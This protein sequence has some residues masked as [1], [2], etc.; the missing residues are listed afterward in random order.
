MIRNNKDIKIITISQLAVWYL[1]ENNMLSRYNSSSCCNSGILCSLLL[2][3]ELQLFQQHKRLHQQQQQQLSFSSG[4]KNKKNVVAAGSDE[5]ELNQA[6]KEHHDYKEFRYTLKKSKQFNINRS[7]KEQMGL[8]DNQTLSKDELHEKFLQR[9]NKK[10]PKESSHQHQQQQQQQQ[11]QQKQELQLQPNQQQKQEQQQM[12]LQQQISQQPELV[13]SRSTDVIDRRLP[14]VWPTHSQLDHQYDDTAGALRTPDNS[15]LDSILSLIQNSLRQLHKR[16]LNVLA[17]SSE[18]TGVSINRLSQNQSLFFKA[19]THPNSVESI[20]MNIFI[21]KNLE[22]EIFKVLEEAM[23]EQFKVKTTATTTTEQQHSKDKERDKDSNSSTAMKD[24]ETSHIKRYNETDYLKRFEDLTGFLSHPVPI[25][26]ASA[27]HPIDYSH[28]GQ[29][30]LQLI[31]SPGITNE[32]HLFD[33]L[34]HQT[35]GLKSS[36]QL[37]PESTTEILSSSTI[38]KGSGT[39]NSSNSSSSSNSNNSTSSNSNNNIRQTEFE[40]WNAN[41]RK[42][43][44]RLIKS[45]WYKQVPRIVSQGVN[46][47][48]SMGVAPNCANYIERYFIN[49]HSQQISNNIDTSIFMHQIYKE[50]TPS[51][52]YE[53][54]R[55]VLKDILPNNKDQKKLIPLSNEWTNIYLRAVSIRIANDIYRCAL[56]NLIIPNIVQTNHSMLKFSSESIRSQLVALENIVIPKE[57]AVENIKEIC[58]FDQLKS[59]S[60]LPKIS[61][62]ISKSDNNSNQK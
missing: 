20:A 9:L 33:H 40:R 44:S 51:I 10:H 50:Q 19:L 15:T 7:V 34:H 61:D 26:I 42:V 41:Y 53:E 4:N 39:G 59:D 57:D 47:F 55:V 36:Y 28:Y 12:L 8:Q 29:E 25:K 14:R 49:E 11:Q 38:K 31:R 52:T 54:F 18:S 2:Q 48:F 13:E 23:T 35:S 27:V 3:Q 43:V 24:K 32:S 60:L 21:K 30:W 56:H 37:W 5:K 46:R 58:G 16:T 1:V 6:L 22:Q 17:L 62:A 45:K